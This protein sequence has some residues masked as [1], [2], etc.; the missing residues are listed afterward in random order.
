[1]MMRHHTREKKIYR[2]SELTRLIKGTL[3]RTFGEVWLEGE[4]S[5]VRRPASGHM[6]F[7]IKDEHAQISG[8]LFRGHQRQI[9]FQPRDGLL[10]RVFGDI[11]VYERSGNYQIIVR[12]LEEGGKGALQAKFEALKE[13]L[14]QEGLFDESRKRTPPVLPQHIGVVTSRTGAA[15]RDMLNVLLRRFPNVHLVLAP[16]KVQGEGAA[17]EIADAVD[18]LNRREDLEILIVGRGGGSLEDLW[19][20]NEEVVARA[21]ARSRLPVLSAVGHEIDFTIS[22]FVADVRAPTPSAAAELVVGRKDTFE[23]RL[24]SLGSGLVRPLRE[25]MLR[26]RHRL[27][28]VEHSYVFREPGN[29]VAQKRQELQALHM[30]ALHELRGVVRERHQHV[31]DM[32]L[33]LGHEIRLR[34][35]AVRQDVRRLEQQMRALSPYAVLHRGYSITRD[36]EGAILRSASGVRAGQRVSTTL[37]EGAFE[38]QVLERS[39]SDTS[40][41]GAPEPGK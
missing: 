30:R 22:D 31:D 8:V 35:Q 20:F 2:V 3:E 28:A 39:T 14:R 33:R 25:W 23:A 9:T 1:M 17:Q 19:C 16:V 26:T 27:A 24:E 5:N 38:S 15:I 4:L 12:R 37:A 11:T 10:V 41:N 7:T 36:A 6:Y 32:R 40:G 13:K 29:M 18:L 21:I 34:W